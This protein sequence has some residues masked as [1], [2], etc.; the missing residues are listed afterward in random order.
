MDFAD[1]WN[2]FWFDHPVL[3]VRLTVFRVVFFGL[4]AFDLWMLMIVHAP[5]YGMAGFNVSHLPFLDGALPLPTAA[6]V[7]V[8][9]LV[10]GFLALRVAFGLATRSS[11]YALTAIYGGVYFWS[12]V[13]SYQHHYLIALILLLCCFLPHE[14][15][16][17]LD[18][19]PKQREEATTSWAARLIYI[20]VSIVYF[21]TAVTKTTQYWM[22]GWALE[23]IIQ[24]PDMRG[25]L[26]WWAEVFGT[27]ELG[28][29][30]FTAHVIMIWQYFVAAAFLFPRLRPIACITGPL[31]HVMVEVIELKIGWFS[32]YMIGLYYI[33]LFPDR[34]FLAVARPVGRALRHLQPAWRWLVR[35]RP[36]DVTTSAVVAVAAAAGSAAIILLAVPVAGRG[37][38]AAVIALLVGLSLR[39]RPGVSAARG[40]ARAGIQVAGVVAMALS[41]RATDALYDYHRY[42]AGDL[43]RRG[44]LTEAAEHYEVANSLSS[45]GP[46]R[47]FQ[48]GE[49]YE[50]LGRLE[51][52]R[53]AYREGL[54][55]A[56][57]DA[58]GH[59]GLARLDRAQS[60]SSSSS[61]RRR[62]SS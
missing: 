17:G 51:D 7:S 24:T 56:P 46:A 35:P 1:R 28:G 21:Y 9:L 34:W 30:A 3:R 58:R 53:R 55:R 8:L 41:L 18:G 31:F 25:F 10:A 45:E 57:D 14:L 12:Q 39:P 19:E 29:Y 6:L 59:R 13:D 20:E 38:L 16:P 36:A 32:W 42:W 4:L 26:A 54:A 48:L 50:R 33:L 43:A 47:F 22:D 61:P 37:V 27:S 60:S 49:I 5:R 23:R 11:L 15:L 62:P 2:R 44:L 52:A 40:H